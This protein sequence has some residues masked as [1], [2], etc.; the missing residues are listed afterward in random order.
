M[1]RAIDFVFS[2][3]GLLLQSPLM[4]LI[5]L[6]IK[7]D[8]P[9][10]V[11]FRQVRVGR[12][13]RH[14][15]IFK[16]RTM[17]HDPEPG[18]Q[19]TTAGDSRITRCGRLLRAGKF[20]ELPQLINVLKGEMSLVGPRPE[21]PRFVEYY[22]EEERRVLELRPGITDPASI[23]YRHESAILASAEDPQ[24]T[25]IEEIMRDKLKINLEYAEKA[26][27]F[28]DFRVILGTLLAVM[29]RH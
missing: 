25:Y 29:R 14:F 10:P 19:I 7:W 22:T 26:G 6:W 11:F 17:A 5:A 12:Q 21:V 23:K 8:S 27:L 4:A 1:K 28:S 18:P 9:G 3:L 20:D 24:R 16:F 13:G 2:S 15:R